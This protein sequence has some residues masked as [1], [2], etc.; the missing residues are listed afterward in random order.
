MAERLLVK[1]EPERT[2]N[3]GFQISIIKIKKCPSI[4]S[5]TQD[6]VV[7]CPIFDQCVHKSEAHKLP[8]LSQDF[9]PI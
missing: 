7:D 3:S 6:C 2:Q 9:T 4:T 8:N 5:T 1:P